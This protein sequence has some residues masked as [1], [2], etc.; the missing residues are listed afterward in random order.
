MFTPLHA[1]S[2]FSV[3]D[4]DA[5]RTFYSDAL[6]LEV[7]DDDMGM[8]QI[9]LPGGAR[10]LAYPKPDHTPASFTILNFVVQ[11]IDA[12]VD[13]LHEKAVETKIYDDDELPTD[14]RGIMRG[15]G[16]TIAWFRD[17]S[18]NVLSIIEDGTP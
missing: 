10:V 4:I 18:G 8:L 17:P 14:D 16:P 13:A 12:A 7:T 5:A 11:D 1:F 3:T 9:A 6:G 15:N 2:G